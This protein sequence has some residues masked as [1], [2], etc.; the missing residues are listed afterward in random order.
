MYLT[1]RMT[2]IFF[3]ETK[4]YV[5]VSIFNSLSD[6]NKF[7]FLFNKENVVSL[8]AKICMNIL[9]RRNSILY[10]I[11]IFSFLTGQNLLHFNV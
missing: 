10:H 4:L 11:A 9:L 8:V 5:L 1:L 3:K 2:C 7:I 6:N